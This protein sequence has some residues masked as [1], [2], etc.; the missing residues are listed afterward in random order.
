VFKLHARQCGA[1]GRVKLWI[2]DRFRDAVAPGRARCLS[3][4]A[5]VGRFDLSLHASQGGAD[6]LNASR[7]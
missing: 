1:L 3:R 2:G 4:K 5:P 6:L 7:C